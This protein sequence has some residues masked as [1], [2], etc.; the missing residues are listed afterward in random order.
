MSQSIMPLIS[1]FTSRKLKC[2]QPQH[3]LFGK[4]H[5]DYDRQKRSFSSVKS[6]LY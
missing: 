2:R 6:D 5:G 4:L 1:C 3:P